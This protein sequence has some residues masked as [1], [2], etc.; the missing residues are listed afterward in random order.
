MQLTKLTMLM[1]ICLLFQVGS[2]IAIEDNEMT[3]N[4]DPIVL[5]TTS[6]GDIK[7]ELYPEKAPETVK[8]FLQY[9]E[10]GFYDGTIFH[11]VI[12]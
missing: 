7:I 2:C 3:T 9:V 1:W 12:D 6:K 10:S 5:M 8:N 4:K 11:R